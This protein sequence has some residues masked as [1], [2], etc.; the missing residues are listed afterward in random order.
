MSPE[1]YQAFTN[2]LEDYF[3]DHFKSDVY[4][5]GLVFLKMGKLS[6]ITSRLERNLLREIDELE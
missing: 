5:L 4:S 6:L 3:Y 2:R 1:L